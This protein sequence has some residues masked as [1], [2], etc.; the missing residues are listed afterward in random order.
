MVGDLLTA[1]QLCS[2]MACYVKNACACDALDAE[3]LVERSAVSCARSG[4]D[5]LNVHRR[6]LT[7]FSLTY[8]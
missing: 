4:H 3:K 7:S 1:V 8:Y 5:T 2:D 6:V